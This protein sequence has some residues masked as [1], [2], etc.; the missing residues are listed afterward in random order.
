MK[1]KS[2]VYKLYVLYDGRARSWGTENSVILARSFCAYKA[3]QLRK[4]DFY[5]FDCVWFE[6]DI[7]NSIELIN[8]KIR[9]DL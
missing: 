6:Y 3:R 9:L 4:N 8:E 1:K 5:G 2:S 7:V